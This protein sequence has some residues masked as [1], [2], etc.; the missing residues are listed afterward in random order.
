MVEP[1]GT[2]ISLNDSPSLSM[3]FTSL[4]LVP[5]IKMET[6]KEHPD[7][8]MSISCTMM[9]HSAIHCWPGIA[10][11]PFRQYRFTSPNF[12][13]LSD[14]SFL[15]TQFDD[16]DLANAIDITAPPSPNNADR[17]ARAK[18]QLEPPMLFHS[19]PPPLVPSPQ[20]IVDAGSTHG[21]YTVPTSAAR[22]LA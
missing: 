4:V 6:P 22:K 17:V 5:I 8:H 3:S 9:L 13:R 1:S 19:A 12:T 7:D 2:A 10:V 15:E 21:T 14:L 11:P 20:L 16:E 18:D